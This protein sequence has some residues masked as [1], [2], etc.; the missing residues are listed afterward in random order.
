MKKITVVLPTFNEAE[1]IVGMIR[2]LLALDIPDLNI[3]VAD[4]ESKDG[5]PQQVLENFAGNNRVRL[6]NHP[7]P[8]GLSPSVVDAFDLSDADLLCCMDADGQHRV[9]DLPGLLNEFNDPQIDM[10]IGS[11][12]IKDGGFAEKWRFDRLLTSRTATCLARIFLQV[13]VH[14]PMSGFFVIRR[15]AY[16]KIRPYLNP[17]GFKIALELAW[18]LTISGTGIVSEHP[19]VFAMRKHGE[20]KLSG[21]VIVQ[22]LKMLFSCLCKKHSI[23]SSIKKTGQKNNS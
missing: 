10:I 4:D 20:S 9:E 17:S 23:K 5:T 2:N 14:D 7:P 19:I 16:E 21:R 12:Y 1:N 15:T 3:I 6:Y 8:H 18:L 13:P 11:R 22:Y